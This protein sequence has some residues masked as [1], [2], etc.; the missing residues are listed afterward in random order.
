MITVRG[1]D[2]GKRRMCGSAD[3]AMGKRWMSMQRTSAFYPSYSLSYVVV[4]HC[5]RP[6]T[7]QT[8]VF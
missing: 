1:G 3:V 5:G 8:I 2:D 6:V 4:V 7:K